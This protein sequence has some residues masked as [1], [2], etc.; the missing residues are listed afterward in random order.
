MGT[1]LIA[2]AIL[3]GILGTVLPILPGLLL[4]WGAVVGYGFIAGFDTV[5]WVA[6][7][8][9]TVFFALGTWWGVRIPQRHAAEIGMRTIDQVAAAICA[10]VGAFVIPVVGLPVG[11]IVGVFVLRLL[12]TMNL[13]AAWTSTKRS[14]VSI[15][16]ASGAQAACGFGIGLVWFIWVAVHHSWI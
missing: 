9:T 8:A 1:V 4:C 15:A 3:V 6:I 14:V 5:A 2:I 11:F 7:A 13:S 10:I 16:K 12:R